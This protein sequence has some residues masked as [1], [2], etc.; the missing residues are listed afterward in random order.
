MS[1]LATF[2]VS[3]RSTP[4]YSWISMSLIPAIFFH[5]M[6][7]FFLLVSFGMFLA[8]SPI[9]SILR[10]T[11][12]WICFEFRNSFLVMCLVYSS[13][14]VMLSSMCS[15]KTLGSLFIGSLF[16]LLGFCL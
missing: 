3:S 15:M 8:A 7:G 16:V 4:K 6:F 14:V 12:S 2:H 1:C 10:M 9:I 13:I 5:G 11:A